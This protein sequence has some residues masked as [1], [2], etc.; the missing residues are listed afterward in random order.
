MAIQLSL[1]H[2]LP[3]G[4]YTL[5]EELAPKGYLLT[6]DVTFEV[7]DTGEIQKRCV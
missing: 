7:K 3:I 4:K 1:I 2:I 6:S 5:R